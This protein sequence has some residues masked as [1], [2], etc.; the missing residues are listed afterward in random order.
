M[1]KPFTIYKLTILYMLS[2]TELPL[3]NFQI[4]NFFM[5]LEYT[6]Y[7]FHVEEALWELEDA[8]LITSEATRTDT[9]YTI[10]AAGTD[11]LFMQRDKMNESIRRDV[12]KFLSDHK[13]ELRKENLALADYYMTTNHEYAVHA[14]M[15]SVEHYP[16][17]DLTLSVHTKAQAEAICDNWRKQNEEVYS[18][19]MD[20]LMQ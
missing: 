6:Y 2:K 15:L 19:L 12:D 3:T 4:V 20:L 7:Y 10:T 1:A 11:T 5:Q 14:R 9:R 17:I 8:G 18:Y 13:Y 16:I